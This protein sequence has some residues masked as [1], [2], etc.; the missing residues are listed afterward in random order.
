[1]CPGTTSNILTDVELQLA[2][3]SLVLN[4]F[5]N[6]EMVIRLMIF[7]HYIIRV[8]QGLVPLLKQLSREQ[9]PLC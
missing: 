5:L 4:E 8:L 7:L 1:M 3:W 6:H 2:R 9:A